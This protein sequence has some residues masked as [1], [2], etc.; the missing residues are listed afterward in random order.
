MVGLYDTMFIQSFTSTTNI[1]TKLA[2]RY[3]NERT[4]FKKLTLLSDKIAFLNTCSKLHIARSVYSDICKITKSV[5]L[6]NTCSY[7]SK[8]DTNL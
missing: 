4:L 8:R 6:Q 2:G 5:K 7:C 1:L 3:F